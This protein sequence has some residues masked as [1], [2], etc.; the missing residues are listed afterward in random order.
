M[1]VNRNDLSLYFNAYIHEKRKKK[2]KLTSLFFLHK[3]KCTFTNFR[4]HEAFAVLINDDWLKRPKRRL[5]GMMARVGL[6]SQPSACF[7]V[8][9]M[10]DRDGFDEA[11]LGLCKMQTLG[12]I[13]DSQTALSSPSELFMPP[14]KSDP[15][16]A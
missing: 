15:P 10:R 4:F 6:C 16:N 8:L 5:C 9:A 3:A 7:F 12:G 11:A 14:T 2:E 1:T 13:I